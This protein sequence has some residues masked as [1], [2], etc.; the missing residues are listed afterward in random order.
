MAIRTYTQFEMRVPPLE[1]NHLVRLRDVR[2]MLAALTAEAAFVVLTE[3]FAA[4]YS[5]SNLTLTQNTAAE[6]VIDGETIS[7]NDRI[8]IAGQLDKTQNGIYVATTLGVTGSTPA[9]LTRAP[10]FNSASQIHNGVIVPVTNGVTNAATRWKL[11]VGALPF[12][13]DSVTLE[14]A[15]DVVD[16]TK[17]AEM[18]FEIE[19]DE[20]DTVYDFAHDWNTMNITHEIYDQDGDTVIAEFRRVDNNSVRVTFGAPLG[21]GNDMTLVIRAQVE[22]V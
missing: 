16:F 18:A 12:V 1:E 21:D 2:E 19:G 11:T 8:L 5:A 3:P 14:F 22:P 4:T 17:V 20:S 6:L 9:V 10:D 7:L 13:L 15:K